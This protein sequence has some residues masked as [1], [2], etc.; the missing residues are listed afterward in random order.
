MSSVSVVPGVKRL[1]TNEW[2]RVAA[3][4][5]GRGEISLLAPDGTFS[6]P[7]R[8]PEGPLPEV[9]LSSDYHEGH[10]EHLRPARARAS[11]R[12]S[13]GTKEAA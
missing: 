5:P 12:R 3:L 4:D 2:I 9:E 7:I 8:G 13:P 11:V 10:R 1:V 6:A